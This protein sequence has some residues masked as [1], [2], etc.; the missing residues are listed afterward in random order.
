MITIDDVKNARERIE[1]VTRG[2]HLLHS[3][4]LSG[5]NDVYLKVESLMALTGDH[6]KFIGWVPI[7]RIL[8]Q[9]EITL[10]E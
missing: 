2:T 6:P 7:N 1:E 4:T 8:K 3:M 9:R 5:E 10:I